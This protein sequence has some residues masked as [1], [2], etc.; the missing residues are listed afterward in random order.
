[1][2]TQNFHQNM[3]STTFS[4]GYNNRSSMGKHIVRGQVLDELSS[5][6]PMYE[7][8]GMLSEIFFNSGQ[9]DG[10]ISSNY[11]R[12]WPQRV[13]L[14]PSES[15]FGEEKHLEDDYNHQFFANN[16]GNPK[17]LPNPNLYP[18]GFHLIN[19]IPSQGL[20]LSL[21][22]SIE[23]AKLE[24]LRVGNG[25]ILYVDQGLGGGA[26]F[27]P[28]G[29]NGNFSISGGVDQNYVQVSNFLRNSKYLKVAQ[30]LLEEMCCVSKGQYKGIMKRVNYKQQM[31]TNTSTSGEDFDASNL[32]SKEHPPLSLA[33]KTQHQRRKVKLLSMLDEVDGRYTRYC[34]RMQAMVNLFDSIVGY[35]AAMSYTALAQRAMSRHFKCIKNAIMTQL[36]ATCQLLG[37]KDITG[38]GGS[39]GLTKG[40]T[41]RLRILDQNF[42]Q[43]KAVHHMGMAEF[44]AWRPQRGL[45]E[46]SVNIL[47]AWMF[48]HFLHPYPSD[49]DKHLLSRQ[50][51]L[52]KNQVS[53][54][55]INARVR[56]WKPMVEEMYQKEAEEEHDTSS[57][58]EQYGSNAQTPRQGSS[59]TVTA[60]VNASQ[61]ITG[62]DIKETDENDP[63][64]NPIETSSDGAFRD[65]VAEF[66][67]MGRGANL[68]TS[69][70]RLG[71]SSSDVSLTLGLRHGGANVSDKSHLKQRNFGAC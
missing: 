61:L 21:S 25:E 28:Y 13:Q 31:P 26:S 53:N 71:A 37:E 58:N 1:M 23:G 20:A 54:W 8:S 52:S 35:G 33:D 60:T 49:A 69:L 30:E 70:I 18:R 39:F 6:V 68:A 66:G 22:S 65:W 43:Q 45:P 40:E 64:R 62:S 50:T 27:S 38:M 48:E 41:P 5:E 11:P 16:I 56:L 4:N 12:S 44:E 15:I 32:S 63:S 3:L 34:E 17:L 59:G 46:R 19:N 9:L 2:G 67:D 24:H 14:Q 57:N 36:K 7:T 51:G 47:R 55:F 29:S 42:R 10:Q